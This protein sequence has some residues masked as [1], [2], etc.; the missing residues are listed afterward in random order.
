[1]EIVAIAI[2]L[3]VATLAIVVA[4]GGLHGARFTITVR[5]PG[6]SGVVIDGDVPGLP[7]N[8]IAELIAGLDLPRGARLW[9]M[10]EGDRVA[11]RFSPTVPEHLH[12][13]LRNF[14]GVM[15]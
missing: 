11:L 2:V 13:R 7:A 12:Q 4:R 6:P 9:G 1:M 14:F 5:G 3:G 8:E 15:R 10:P